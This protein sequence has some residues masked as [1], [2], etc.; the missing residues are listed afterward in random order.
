[1]SETHGFAQANAFLGIDHGL[2]PSRGLTEDDF[3]PRRRKLK[4]D[5][6]RSGRRDVPNG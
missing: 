6:K 3:R 4:R 5:K 2:P 1:M